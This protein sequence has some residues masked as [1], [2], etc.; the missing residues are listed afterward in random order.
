MSLEDEITKS[1][2]VH[3]KWKQRILNVIQTGH[4]EWD[5]EKV[6]QDNQCDFGKWLYTCN[7]Q[8]KASPHYE[9]VKQIH[10]QFHKVA[11]GALEM[12]LT[13]DKEQARSAVNMDSEYRRISG[14]L[15]SEMMAWKRDCA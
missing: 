7:P 11:G 4:S 14:K 10:A 15:T 2:G 9:N 12:A 6:C 8:E 3:G 1:I 13:G 5:P